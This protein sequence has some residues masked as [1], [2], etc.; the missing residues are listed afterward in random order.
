[1]SI[2][3]IGTLLQ[4]I[5][6]IINYQIYIKI[7]KRNLFSSVEKMWIKDNF[8]FMHNNDSKHT[9]FDTRMLILH[10]RQ[11]IRYPIIML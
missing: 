7:L 6:E 8:I 10:N 5:N 4:F 9:A 1:M 2:H 3:K 11:R